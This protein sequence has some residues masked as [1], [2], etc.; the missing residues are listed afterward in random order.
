VSVASEDTSAIDATLLSSFSSA[1]NAIGIML[2]FNSIGW[3]PSNLLFNAVDA[4]LGDPLISTA[5]SG[6][7]PATTL[8]YVDRSDVK[9]DG[10]GVSATGASQINSTVSNAATSTASALWKATSQS[11]GG[12]VASNKVNSV[13]KAYASNGTYDAGTGAMTVEADNAAGVFTNDKLVSSSIT[14][15]DGG[16]SVIQSEIDNFVPADYATDSGTQ[17]ISFGQ[18]V[19]IAD[20]FV[21][22]T[23]TSD[24]IAS[25]LNPG[26]EVTLADDFGS[27]RL[28]SSSGRRLVMTGDN[29]AVDDG[30]TKGG[31]PGLTYQWTGTSGLLDLG[32]QNYAA[33][34]WLLIGGTPGTVY[35]YTGAAATN[36]DLNAQDYTSSDWVA[37][38]GTV[39]S[40]YEYMGT[41]QS[42]DL[43]QQDYTDLNLWKP[44]SGTNLIPQGLNVTNSD[45]TGVGALIAFNDVRSDTEAYVLTAVVKAGSLSVN[46]TDEAVIR[47][48]VDSSVSSSGGS[49][50]TGN[51]DS[52]AG[53]GV[54]ATNAVLD[55][56]LAKI[57]GS[58]VT[59]DDEI[60]VE[61]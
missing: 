30:Y 22:P 8:A 29:V 11:I 54:L 17:T 60:A 14:T 40:V 27:S 3:K 12:V 21:N 50:F 13:T 33:G 41:T 1:G 38:G 52:I 19:R 2:A 47:A 16:A 56:T 18:T 44:A 53:N 43:A 7:Q 10:L 61:A 59:T 45:A 5:F 9:S 55:T 26:D 58:V 39:G 20:G 6:S 57:D 32:A 48:V 49:S 46:A 36:V 15:N 37:L 35:Q 23:Y 51:G 42:R 24:E 31:T 34:D 28:T 4:L 25:T